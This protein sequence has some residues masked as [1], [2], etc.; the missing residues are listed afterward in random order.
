MPIISSF[1]NKAFGGS[2]V[3]KNNAALNPQYTIFIDYLLVA[4]GGG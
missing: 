4:G 1:S 3:L 2:R